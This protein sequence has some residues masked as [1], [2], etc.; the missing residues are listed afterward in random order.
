MIGAGYQ[1]ILID[2]YNRS[3]KVVSVMNSMSK[4]NLSY[5]RFNIQINLKKNQ[6]FECDLFH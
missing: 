2:R 5:S 3:K 6:C 4:L 1:L